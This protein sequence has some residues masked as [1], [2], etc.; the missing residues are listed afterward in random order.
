MTPRFASI[1]IIGA[2]S[3]IGRACALAFARTGVRVVASSRSAEA[4]QRLAAEGPAGMI[5]PLALDATDGDACTAV[6]TAA[7]RLLGHAPEA[8]LYAAAIPSGERNDA[9]TA[10]ALRAVF[11]V[12]VMGAIHALAVALPAMQAAGRGHVALISSVAGFRGLPQALAYGASKA[13]L[14]HVAEALRFDCAPRGIRVQVIH[15]GFVRTPLTAKNRFPMPFL[16][17]PD[18]AARRIVDGMARTAFEITFPRR[19]TWGLK[20]LR[21]LPYGLYFRLVGRA[22]RG[23]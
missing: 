2:S 18:A 12:N 15:P 19:F 17:E 10:A 5:V 14:T 11:D 16:M 6:H 23:L 8:L 22:T 7:T 3:G 4:L 21:C 20:L 13:A 9:V 1:W